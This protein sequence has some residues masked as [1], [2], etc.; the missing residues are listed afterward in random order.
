MSDFNNEMPTMDHLMVLFG[1]LGDGEIYEWIKAQLCHAQNSEIQSWSRVFLCFSCG[2][3][4][5]HGL[6]DVAPLMRKH[7]FVQPAQCLSRQL[8]RD[9]AEPNLQDFVKQLRCRRENVEICWTW[10]KR[11]NERSLAGLAPCRFWHH[12]SSQKFRQCRWLLKLK[13]LQWI[14]AEAE[15]NRESQWVS[16]LAAGGA[17]GEFEAKSGF[18]EQCVRHK[19]SLVRFDLH[20]KLDRQHVV[21][22]DRV[23]SVCELMTPANSEPSKRESPSCKC[24]VQTHPPLH[25]AESHGFCVWILRL[26]SLVLAGCA[27]TKTAHGPSAGHG[28]LYSFCSGTCTWQQARYCQQKSIQSWAWQWFYELGKQPSDGIWDTVYLIH[29]DSI[30]TDKWYKTRYTW[31]SIKWILFRTQP[32]FSRRVL[33]KFETRSSDDQRRTLSYCSSAYYV[34]FQIYLISLK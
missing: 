7:H 5:G 4:A 25:D 8:G 2:G 18:F 31:Q 30:L 1:G 34:I 28:R 9:P 3:C 32:A 24:G 14:L 12:V 22:P 6:C 16:A 23:G 27:S 33:Q 19:R 26:C 21:I 13:G 11:R 15:W 17:R 20:M 10:E 29:L